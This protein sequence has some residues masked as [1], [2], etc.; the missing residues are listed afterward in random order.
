MV[1]KFFPFNLL[2]QLNNWYMASLAVVLAFNQLV[3]IMSAPKSQKGGFTLNFTKPGAQLA[4]LKPWFRFDSLKGSESW[5]K[6]RIAHPIYVICL[7]IRIFHV[8]FCSK[9]QRLSTELQYFYGTHRIPSILWLIKKILGHLLTNFNTEGVNLI[10]VRV[11]KQLLHTDWALREPVQLSAHL[12]P[13][14]AIPTWWITWS[15]DGEHFWQPT[16]CFL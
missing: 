14:L 3:I 13:V 15:Q 8:K 1:C 10:R 9:S 2:M 12:P 4:Y 16:W 7:C 5:T 6:N 11:R